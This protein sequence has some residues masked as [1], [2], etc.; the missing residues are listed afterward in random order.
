MQVTEKLRIKNF[1]GIKEADIDLSKFLVLI[2]PQ[3]SGKSLISKVIYWARMSIS[4]VYFEVQDGSTYRDILKSAKDRFEE[5]FVLNFEENF[6]IYYEIGEICF[7]VTVSSRKSIKLEF[8]EKFAKLIGEFVKHVRQKSVEDEIDGPRRASYSRRE[9][10]KFF[11]QI[12]S[13]ASGQ[14]S[15]VRWPIYAPAAR[16][17]FSQVEDSLF[18]FLS[19]SKRLD[20]VV[21]GFGDYLSWAKERQSRALKGS[22][23]NQFLVKLYTEVLKGKYVREDRHDYI[24]HA[25]GRRVPLSAASS[26]QQEILPLCL[27]LNEMAI[28]GSAPRMFIIEEPEAHLHPTAQKVILEAIVHAASKSNGQIILTTH[29]PYVLT[30]LNNLYL[31]GQIQKDQPEKYIHIQSHSSL[32]FGSLIEPGELAAYCL[33]NG[34]A[35]C[36]IDSETHLMNADAIDTVSTELSKDFDNLLDAKY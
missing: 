13:E 7:T 30:V 33:S 34:E 16:S 10:R 8:C 15:T 24:Q 19:S 29:S 31:A 2:G 14:E 3:S 32:V 35:S 4:N 20:P 25:D 18:V 27:I 17:F 23:E 6:E 1:C 28:S 26:G 12:I 36:L 21:E 11:N 9:G 22:V 5:L